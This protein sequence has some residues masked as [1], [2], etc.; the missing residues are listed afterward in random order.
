M[1]SVQASGMEFVM[2]A[3]HCLCSMVEQV[4]SY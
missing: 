3:V 4:K 2:Q 1:L